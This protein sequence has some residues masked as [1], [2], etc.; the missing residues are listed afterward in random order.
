M[1]PAYFD[2]VAAEVDEE[3]REVGRCRLTLSKPS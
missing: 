2:A 1:T 3:L